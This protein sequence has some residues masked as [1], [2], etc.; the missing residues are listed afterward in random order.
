[1]SQYAG[2][3]P[4]RS[5]RHHYVEEHPFVFTFRLYLNVLMWATS[6]GPRFFRRAML[7]REAYDRA[8]NLSHSL[9]QVIAVAGLPGEGYT[10]PYFVP[11]AQGN[12]GRFLLY[13]EGY[14]DLFRE[15]Y[16]PNLLRVN[17]SHANIDGEIGEVLSD[18]RGVMRLL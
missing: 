18:V 4:L 11:P 5:D 1:M 10:W 9:L 13:L 15:V 8:V 3:M 17:P 12:E 7:E 6:V 16:L 2:M 14:L